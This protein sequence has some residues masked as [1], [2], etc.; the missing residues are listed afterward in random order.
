MKNKNIV[1]DKGPLLNFYILLET[2][3]IWYYEGRFIPYDSLFWLVKKM[4]S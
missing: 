3:E 1:P 4:S 2:F